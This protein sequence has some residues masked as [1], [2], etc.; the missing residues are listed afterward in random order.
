MTIRRNSIVAVMDGDEWSE[1]NYR[2]EEVEGNSVR[3]RSLDTYMPTMEAL[4]N[5]TLCYQA[6]TFERGDTV[7]V[8][9]EYADRYNETDGANTLTVVRQKSGN[10]PTTVVRNNNGDEFSILNERIHLVRPA[11]SFKAGDRVV[12]DPDLMEKFDNDGLSMYWENVGVMVLTEDSGSRVHAT[13]SHFRYEKDGSTNNVPTRWLKLYEEPAKRVVGGVIK[14]A[15]IKVGDKI[16][17]SDTVWGLLREV[18]G[19]VAGI[20]CSYGVTILRTEDNGIFP[21]ESNGAV[22]TLLEEAPEPVDENLQ[23]LLDAE[24]GDIAHG[25]YAAEYWKK[26]GDDEWRLLELDSGLAVR[27]TEHVFA[28][29][30]EIKYGE[31]HIFKKVEDAN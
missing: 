18:T 3:V 2:V 26:V 4:D 24:I 1:T 17:A 13:T 15:D 16:K 20:S 11:K 23:R 10:T 25:T 22:F 30:H 5:L 19:V 8:R 9:M 27:T 31:L 7:R 14:V 6:D 29:F 12:I 28:M 21:H